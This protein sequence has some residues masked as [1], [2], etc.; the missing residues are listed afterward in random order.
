MFMLCNCLVTSHSVQQISQQVNT[1]SGSMA[2]IVAGGQKT[3]TVTTPVVSGISPA[4]QFKVSNLK[5][6]GFVMASSAYHTQGG[7]SV[8]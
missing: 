3:V 2:A 1:A 6:T 5:I 4:I 7:P 8:L